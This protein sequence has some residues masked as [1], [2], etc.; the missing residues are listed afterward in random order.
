[1]GG[2]FGTG[3][4]Y[5]AGHCLYRLKR[6]VEIFSSASP[7]PDETKRSL[8]PAVRDDLLDFIANIGWSLVVTRLCF[9]G[10]FVGFAW[11]EVVINGSAWKK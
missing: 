9:S 6:E 5:L 7:H 1:M 3:G 4:R 8:R 2:Y 10:L 11:D